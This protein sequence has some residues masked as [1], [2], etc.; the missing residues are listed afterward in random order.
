MYMRTTTTAQTA[1]AE[2][3]NT[4]TS[5]QTRGYKNLRVIMGQSSQIETP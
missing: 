3:G 5:A 4:I 2:Q 1:N